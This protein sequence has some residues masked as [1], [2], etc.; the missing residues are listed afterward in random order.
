MLV[1][2]RALMLWEDRPKSTPQGESSATDLL[3]CAQRTPYHVEDHTD[4]QAATG[5]HGDFFAVAQIVDCDL[6][7][8]A[9]WARICVDL[10]IW[11]EGHILDLDLVIDVECF[12]GHFEDFC[13]NGVVANE[14][15]TL[16]IKKFGAG[17]VIR[18]VKSGTSSDLRLSRA[19]VRLC[20]FGDLNI[21]PKA[22]LNSCRTVFVD[23]Q[24]AVEA[25][26]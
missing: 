18:G 16:Q 22:D 4:H 8:V 14:S 19:V 7:A 10:D 12:V 24:R 5:T 3:S 15:V 26:N 2:C 21:K 13:L 6:E 20:R 25:V 9:T 11:I 17:H 23:T 1:F